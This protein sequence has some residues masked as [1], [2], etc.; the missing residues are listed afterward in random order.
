M[1]K[2]K[3]VV[4]DQKK[5]DDVYFFDR[6]IRKILISWYLFVL[7]VL[8]VYVLLNWSNVLCFSSLTS[9]NGKNFLFF[10][11]VALCILPL[12]GKLEAFGIK[13]ESW[14]NKPLTASE[15]EVARVS[16]VNGIINTD[17][18]DHVP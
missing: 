15:K 14:S 3:E 4:K 8:T 13:Y 2:G 18:V 6:H 11:W 7:A 17:G 16:V 10:V 5:S 1:A 12:V 9:I